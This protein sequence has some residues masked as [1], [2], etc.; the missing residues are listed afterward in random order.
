MFKIE[1]PFPVRFL[2]PCHI[3]N[4]SKIEII[5]SYKIKIITVN[6][7]WISQRDFG[8]ADTISDILKK[9]LMKE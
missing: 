8:S 5:I 9:H 6:S 1:K 4:T 2:K 7:L 3:G